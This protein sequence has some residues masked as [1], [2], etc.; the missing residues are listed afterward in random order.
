MGESAK[1][2]AVLQVVRQR[3]GDGTLKPGA[4]V[5]AAAL[6]R[7]TG[8]SV[9]T[10]RAA[11]RLLLAD[12]T[13]VEGA[14]K[15]A[16]F[17]VAVPGASG[18]TAQTSQAE[19]SR[20]LASLRRAR[21]LTQPQLAAE[22]GVSVTAV[23][24]AETGRTW[25]KAD[26][27]HRADDVL[28]GRGKLV[29]LYDRYRAAL[30]A[31]AGLEVSGQPGPGTQPPSP[32]DRDP[33]RLDEADSKGAALSLPGAADKRLAALLTPAE[34]TAVRDAGLLYTWIA[35]HVI[36]DGPAREDDLAELRAQVP[37]IQRMVLAQAAARALP[38]EFRLLGGLVTTDDLGKQ[39]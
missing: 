2:D 31:K 34:H 7:E 17:K 35:T 20:T 12:G 4:S 28:S 25:Q 1:R 18:D 23:G 30:A 9:G 8:T 19:L 15:T 13:L 36:P 11:L 24:H 32:G 39:R 26:F 10:S 3:I 38:D 29:S 22:L 21:G 33:A 5:A 16:Q 27:W 37:V 14:S 6:A